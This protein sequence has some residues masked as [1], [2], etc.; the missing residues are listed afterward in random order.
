MITTAHSSAVSSARACADIKPF[1]LRNEVLLGPADNACRPASQLRG[2]LAYRCIHPL[3]FSP[4]VV[5]VF[6]MRNQS[7]SKAL[8]TVIEEYATYYDAANAPV[9]MNYR[10]DFQPLYLPECRRIH[11][12]S[13]LYD[14]AGGCGMRFGASYPGSCRLFNGTP[15]LSSRLHAADLCGT[16]CGCRVSRSLACSSIQA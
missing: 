3:G 14:R 13:A 12:A 7:I 9:S 6:L 1:T 15:S 4:V 2:W 5:L 16:A 10:V 11:F 8:C